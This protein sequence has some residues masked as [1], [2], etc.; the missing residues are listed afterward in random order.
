MSSVILWV[1]FAP[2][3]NLVQDYFDQES[4]AHS[5][6][7]VNMMANIFYIMY[8]P[9]TILGN[10]SVSSFGQA[11]AAIV[12][13]FLLNMPATISMLWFASNERDIATTIGAMVCP[14]SLAIGQIIPVVLVSKDEV[15]DDD[16]NVK[17]MD[18]L[19]LTE[20][21][22]VLVPLFLTLFFFSALPPSPPSKAAEQKII[23]ITNPLKRDSSTIN[24]DTSQL[25]TK[26]QSLYSNRHY[27]QLF[28]AFSLGVGFFYT[29]LTL[30]NQLIRPHGYSNDD[31]GTFGSVFIVFGLVGAAL[32]GYVM[33]RTKAY[34]TILKV[35]GL[36]SVF[37]AIFLLGMLYKD[38]FA[39][40][41]V[42]FSILGF[43]ALPLLPVM[44][45]N[46]AE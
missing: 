7:A 37:S 31:A 41:L 40:I 11:L 46:C 14:L 13:P 33:E 22:L 16:V 28:C 17:G 24:G 34:R 39:G 43:F 27:V 32:T 1:T 10:L 42:A 45:E 44:M 23:L 30:L 5:I 36:A 29:L 25:F 12:Q 15:S 18:D 38:N 35:E 9:G 19:M 21:I 20:F 8:A 6:T 4:F 2:I 3:S 26:L